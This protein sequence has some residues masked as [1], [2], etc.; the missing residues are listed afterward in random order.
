[1]G[2]NRNNLFISV[3]LSCQA[4]PIGYSDDLNK[5]Q[6]KWDIS[7]FERFKTAFA[8]KK[9]AD[10]VC[11]YLPLF[12]DLLQLKLTDIHLFIT[13]GFKVIPFLSAGNSNKTLTHISGYKC[14]KEIHAQ[15]RIGEGAEQRG[16]QLAGARE[17]LRVSISCLRAPRQ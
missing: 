13:E 8:V 2:F 15:C 12:K 6:I 5:K 17:Q 1:M 11:V 16:C 14:K 10:Y 7:I 3:D 4:K 9:V